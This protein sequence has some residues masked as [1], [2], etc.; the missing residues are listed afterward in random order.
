MS[1]DEKHT[2]TLTLTSRTPLL[3]SCG[4]TLAFYMTT[5]QQLG[6]CFLAEVNDHDEMLSIRRMLF[7]PTQQSFFILW[8]VPLNGHGS[9]N[10][11]VEYHTEDKD[12]AHQV[13]YGQLTPI[14]E[15]LS[16]V[17]KFSMKCRTKKID[18][19]Y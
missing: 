15:L 9:V 6:S 4:S 5:L 8:F 3:M 7:H 13:I 10:D 19:K 18:N 14:Q 11:L 12:I 17:F 16:R 1:K 2:P